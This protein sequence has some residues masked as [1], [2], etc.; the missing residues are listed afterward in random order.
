MAKFQSLLCLSSIP[1]YIYV[2]IYFVCS[3]VDGRLA[4]FHILVIVIN[5]AIN[6]GVHVSFRIGFFSFSDIYPG[7][8]LLGHMV[9]LFF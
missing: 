9:A 3:S 2:Y 1:S 6:I 4:C 7:V 8:E 5:S